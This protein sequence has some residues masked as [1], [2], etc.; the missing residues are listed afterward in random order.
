MKWYMVLLVIALIVIA[1]VLVLPVQASSGKVCQTFCF[2]EVALKNCDPGMHHCTTDTVCV[3]AVEV[4]W[5][6]S[7]AKFSCK[8]AQ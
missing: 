1:L 5:K 2:Q 8:E 3:R 7:K 6:A 4:C